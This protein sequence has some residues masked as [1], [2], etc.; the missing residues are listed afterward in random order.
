LRTF[1]DA[2]KDENDFTV[3]RLIEL[4]KHQADGL[5]FSTED[6]EDALKKGKKALEGYYKTY[7]PDWNRRLLTEYAVRGTEVSVE[8]GVKLELSGK[9]D[10]IELLD[11]RHVN[12]V[13]YKTGKPK[14]RNQIEGKVGG[15]SGGEGNYFRQLAFY[16]LLLDGDKKFIMKSG[17]IDFIEPNERGKYKKERFE[18]ESKDIEKVKAEIVSMAKDILSLSFIASK[19]EDKKCEY[20]KLGKLLAGK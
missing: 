9:L 19:C 10:K 1:F 4:F 6:R 3:R 16:K 17:E 12:V 14:S 8:K 15:E 11:D 13:D 7:Y 18:I 20:C 2:Y 5:P